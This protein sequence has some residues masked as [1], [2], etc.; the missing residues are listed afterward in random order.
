[1]LNIL[2]QSLLIALRS[3]QDRANGAQ[4]NTRR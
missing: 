2:A 4:K 3:G 1:M